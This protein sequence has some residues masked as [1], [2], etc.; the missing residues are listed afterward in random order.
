M[1]LVLICGSAALAFSNMIFASR[2]V[3]VMAQFSMDQA[4]LTAISSIGFLPGAIFSIVLGNFFDRK[5]GKAI[6]YV[7]ALMLLISTA[8]LVWRIFASDYVQLVVITF[9]AGT[10]FLPTQVLPA[11]LVEAWF[12]REQIGTAMGLWGASSGFGICLAFFVGGVVPTIQV[13]FI[14]CVIVFAAVSVLW[15]LFG[16]MPERLDQPKDVS[17]PAAER[18]KVSLRMVLKSK[19]LWL[20]MLTCGLVAS[21]PLMIN[22]CMVNAFLDKGLDPALASLLG[23]FYNISLMLGSVI[24]GVVTAK[25]GRYNPPFLVMCVGGGALLLAAYLAPA[26]PATFV[27]LVCSGLVVSGSLAT[28]LARVGLLPLTGD[29]GP[30]SIG[31]AGGMN[32]TSMGVFNFILPTAVASVL[33]ANYFG[34]FIAALVFLCVAGAIG[35]F[36][37]P[38]LGERGKL[39]RRARGEE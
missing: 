12:P 8:F 30:E 34:I 23:V 1:L 3:E 11:K 29:F 26:G 16:R 39:A 18:P 15:L 27:L 36:L 6:R 33:G 17:S 2:P 20:V 5:G 21:I 28:S 9:C 38:E 37:I 10:L 4:Q 14:V 32:N 7:G 24:A 13:G 22:T 25:L 19:N 35:A 31:S